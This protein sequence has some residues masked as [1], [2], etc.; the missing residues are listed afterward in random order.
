MFH[1]HKVS[2]LCYLHLWILR[3]ESWQN[4]L[5]FWFSCHC[6]SHGWNSTLCLVRL[7]FA[8]YGAVVTYC[9]KW[10]MSNSI[11]TTEIWIRHCLIYFILKE[12][13]DLQNGKIYMQVCVLNYYLINWLVYYI[14]L[15]INLTQSR[16]TWKLSPLRNMFVMLVCGHVCEGLSWFT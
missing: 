13:R 12:Y 7:L 8:Q 16:V 10:K 4:R 3:T 5:L 14:E 6:H 11:L 1:K 2:I 9:R 15:T